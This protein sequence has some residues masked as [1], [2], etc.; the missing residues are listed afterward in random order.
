MNCSTRRAKASWL[1]DHV[2]RPAESAL[3]SNYPKVQADHHHLLDFITDCLRLM[4]GSNIEPMSWM[5]NWAGKAPPR[6]DG[7]GARADQVADGLP[8]F[9]IVA[10]VLGIVT[11][12]SIGGDIVEV[13]GHVAGALVGTFLGILL[14]YGFVGR[15]PRAEATPAGQPHL[16]IG[17]DRPAGLPARLQPAGGAG[18][19]PQDAAHRRAPVVHRFEST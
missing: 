5:L 9:G 3:F 17:Q 16:R 10:A 1:E 2:E 7:A 13:G 15:W 18:I 14:A 8:G 4:I 6:S 11:M 12:G 19:C